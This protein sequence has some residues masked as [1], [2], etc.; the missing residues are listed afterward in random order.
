MPKKPPPCDVRIY[1]QGAVIA[2]EAC[3]EAG[4]AWMEQAIETD[5]R[6]AVQLSLV[7]LDQVLS[8]AQRARLKLSTPWGD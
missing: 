1:Y 5:G 7:H 2:L 6:R 8:S 3:S 4:K